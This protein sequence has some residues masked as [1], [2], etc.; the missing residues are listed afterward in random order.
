MFHAPPAGGR[1]RDQAAAAFPQSSEPLEITVTSRSILR[2]S[3]VAAALLF[4]ITPAHAQ[5]GG[6]RRAA[7][8]AAQGAAGTPTPAATQQAQ[9]P[10][11]ASSR[12]NTGDVLEMTAPVLDRF[13][14]G[15]AAEQADR[16]QLARQLAASVKTPEQYQQCS[17]QWVMSPAGQAAMQK[18]SAASA[19]QTAA[20]TAVNEMKAALARVCGLDP[21]E[22]S[23]MQS[24]AQGHATAAGVAAGGFTAREYAVIKERVV[25]FCRAQDAAAG[26]G[27]VHL[28]GRGTNVYFVYTPAEAAALRTRC[29]ALMQALAATS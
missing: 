24:D 8:R 6:L 25:P 23:R 17:T 13:Q 3:A 12:V 18:L 28:P 26:D 9:A 2:A 16:A 1:L 14:R 20:T 4:A 19:D 7:Q 22:R 5:L 10:A 11:S 27:D 15:L 21:S 29:G